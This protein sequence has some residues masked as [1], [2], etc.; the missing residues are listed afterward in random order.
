MSIR[1]Y[2]VAKH[3]SLESWRRCEIQ[4]EDFT[5]TKVTVWIQ[6]CPEFRIE[7]WEE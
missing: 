5:W 4:L 1:G 2:V 7:D 6:F 3:T